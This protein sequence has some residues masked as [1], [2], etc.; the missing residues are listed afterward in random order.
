[1][2]LI[3]AVNLSLQVFHHRLYLLAG[4]INDLYPKLGGALADGTELPG[5]EKLLAAFSTNMMLLARR[6][7]FCLLEPAHRLVKVVI[8][9]VRVL[10][11]IHPI[12]AFKESNPA[13]VI[14][15]NRVIR[16]VTAM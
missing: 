9:G 11:S 15:M 7:V 3:S 14:V 12:L 5:G 2:T 6:H 16:L 10:A 13:A 1:M 8:V 4:P